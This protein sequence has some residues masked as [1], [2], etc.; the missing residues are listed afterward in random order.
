[1]PKS[2]S[3]DFG[4]NCTPIRSITIINWMVMGNIGL[5]CNI[6]FQL[7]MQTLLDFYA[8]FIEETM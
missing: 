5:I 7:K 4:I 2:Y 8:L 1:M 6:T 3:Y